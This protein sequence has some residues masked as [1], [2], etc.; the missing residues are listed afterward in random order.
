MNPIFAN[1][2]SAPQ[3]IALLVIGVLIFGRKLPEVGR[4]LGKGIVEFKRGLAGLEDEISQGTSGPRHE[5]PT[6]LVEAPRPPQRVATAA[7]KFEDSPAN[8][9]TPPHS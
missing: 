2:L 1:F 8:I 5:T 9:P 7:P 6:T 4:S 3:L